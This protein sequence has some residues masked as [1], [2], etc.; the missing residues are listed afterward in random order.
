MK[1]SN[2]HD[3]IHPGS[4]LV[5]F[6]TVFVDLLGFGLVLP[7]LPIYADQFSSDESGLEVGLLMASF[8]AMQFL[9]AP[10]WG[11]LSDKIGRRPVIMIGLLGSAGFYTLFG[12]ATVWKSIF[13]VFVSRIG[14]GIA[15]A[16]I[17]TAQAY[18]ADTTTAEKRTHGMALIGMAFGLGFTFGPIL[19]F[20]ALTGTDGELSPLPG[21]IAAGLSAVAFLLALFLLPESLTRDSSSAARKLVDISAIKVA[22]KTRVIGLILCALFVCVYSFAMFETTLSL[23]IKNEPFNYS[24]QKVCAFYAFIGVS[25]AI[26]QGGIVRR[27]F[28]TI[29]R[30]NACSIRGRY[31]GI[32]TINCCWRSI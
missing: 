28:E 21:Y 23:L 20:F 32:R 22:I 29:C 9:V 12:L 16:T 15:G 6:L 11:A 13:W 2:S 4:L 14:A 25:L 8:S 31:Q 7:L 3:S 24:L 19:G 10:I 1:T 18:I 26:I 27:D 17:P 5:I 30:C